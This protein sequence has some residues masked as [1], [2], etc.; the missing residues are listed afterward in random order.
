MGNL[1]SYFTWQRTFDVNYARDAR[2]LSHMLPEGSLVGA[3]NHSGPLRL[4]SRMQSF[5]WCHI[6]TPA[7]LRWALSVGRPVF[8]VL[9]E[10]ESKCNLEASLIATRAGMITVGTLPSGKSLRRIRLPEAP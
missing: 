6:E 2:Y 1:P 7:L 8:V 3:L 9:D 10:Q 5:L 4:Y